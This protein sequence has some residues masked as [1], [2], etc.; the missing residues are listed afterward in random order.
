LTKESGITGFT[1][2]ASK[3]ATAMAK[4][5][6]P[7]ATARAALTDYG[8][9]GAAAN[10]YSIS[11]PFVSG[12]IATGVATAMQGYH[13]APWGGA[14]APAPTPG[15][16]GTTGKSSGLA[17]STPVVMNPDT[18][19]PGAAPFSETG[20]PAPPPGP[21]DFGGLN[22]GGKN[23]LAPAT[24]PVA[25]FS[26][27][28]TAPLT[29]PGRSASLGGNTSIQGIGTTLSVQ[30]FGAGGIVKKAYTRRIAGLG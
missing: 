14:P 24:S 1:V 11:N 15:K 4:A 22:L 26:P 6:I 9:K 17:I 28:D 25:P 21:G 19:S 30:S 20:Q 16:A 18:F 7:A 29:G 8:L 3:A 5:G 12:A 2:A 13:A 23:G 10:G 27:L